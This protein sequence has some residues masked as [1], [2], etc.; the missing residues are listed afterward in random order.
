MRFAMSELVQELLEHLSLE[1]LEDNLFRG[2]S[3]DIGGKSVFGG[4]V[5]GQALVAAGQTV[6]GRSTHSLH[7]Y[8]LRPGDHNAPIVYEVERIRD[9]SSFTTRRVVA[10]QHGRPIFNMSASF[11]IDEEGVGHQAPMPEAPPPE[12]LLSIPELR[13]QVADRLPESRRKILTMDRPIEIRPVDPGDLF[14]PEPRPPSKQ[15][16]FRAAG[17]LPEDPALHQT[18]L[19]Y[20]S[21]FTLLMTAFLPHGLSFFRRGLQ[22]ASLD[23]AMWFHRPFCM[24]DWLLYDMD[25]PSAANCR[26][27]CRGN[28]FTRDGQL[29]ASVA[30]EGL[31]RLR[32]VGVC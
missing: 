9:G 24:D 26:G 32:E 12:G 1:R 25:S 2:D 8:F 19:A 30:Q 13:R 4:Q 29:V 28:I 21:D 10:I 14:Q 3:R 31:I 7:G 22:V 15:V 27:L 6:K 23:H 18:V 11:Q 20:A 17:S 16:W 5:L